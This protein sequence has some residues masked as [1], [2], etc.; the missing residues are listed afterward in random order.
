MALSKTEIQR[1]LREMN[2]KFDTDESYEALMQRLQQKNHSLWLKSVHGL[3]GSVRVR[4]RPKPLPPPHGRTG[5]PVP[6][7]P[8][9]PGPP[10]PG[11]PTAPL[12]AR[13]PAWRPRPID[14]P[15]PGKPWKPAADGTQPFNR[16]QNV[17]DF[18]LRRARNC[19]EGCG[20]R[21]GQLSDG[22]KLQPFH[23]LPLS[24]G[25]QHS[26]KNVVALCTVCREALETHP[27]PKT[28]KDLKRKTRSKL[29][30]N[31]KTV[32]KKPL[33]RRPR[34]PTRKK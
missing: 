16:T 23:I 32:R 24:H 17:F 34:Y 8:A 4:K 10:G 27:S 5:D 29:Y 18:V 15:S 7:V 6:R 9:M 3:A 19:C 22:G 33:G 20:S 1:M 12:A 31:V 28:I 25:G 26:V 30:E 13:K 14:K 2:V 11:R 21:S